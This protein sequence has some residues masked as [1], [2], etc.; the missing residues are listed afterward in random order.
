[1]TKR[2]PPHSPHI[3][4]RVRKECQINDGIQLSN[5]IT[6]GTNWAIKS[7]GAR[8]S[9]P[10]ES[11]FGPPRSYVLKYVWLPVDIGKTS[12]GS[13]V[14]RS[15]CREGSLK[16]GQICGLPRR[17][18]T[19]LPSKCNP[20]TTTSL[21]A[22][23]SP[24]PPTRNPLTTQKPLINAQVKIVLTLMALTPNPA[25]CSCT[26]DQLYAVW[27]ERSSLVKIEEKF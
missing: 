20:I 6:T 3:T 9:G 13:E 25:R 18:S 21:Y 10:P 27:A 19:G 2:P 12:R 16:P 17:S 8:K 23:V 22:T 11:K 15:I 5:I 1:M 4:V 26:G 24:P 14:K 7:V